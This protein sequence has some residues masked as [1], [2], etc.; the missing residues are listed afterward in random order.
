MKPKNVL[1]LL[2][3]GTKLPA[4]VQA[5]HAEHLKR[6]LQ[7]YHRKAEERKVG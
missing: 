2:K 1:D 5:K 4:Y 3:D 6:I 7:F